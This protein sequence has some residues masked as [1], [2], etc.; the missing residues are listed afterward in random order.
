MELL[1]DN[2]L[3]P[4]LPASAFVVVKRETMDALVGQL[5]SP[6]Y[7]S[8]RVLREALFPKGD[9]ELRQA[10][11]ETVATISLSD[12]K[13][14]YST[15]FRPD[16]TTIV[17]VGEVTPEQARQVVE[18]Y[19]GGWKAS[20]LKPITDYPPVP[21]NKPSAF[22]VP[23]SSRVQDEVTLAE[24][25]GIMR[26]D[27]DYYKLKLGNTVLSGAFYASRLSSDL[28]EK[29]GLVYSVESFLEAKKARSIFGIEF[30]CDPPNVT[31]SR[32]ITLRD[33]EAMQTILVTPEELR[34]AKMLLLHHIP[35]SESSVDS[36]A[37][38]LLDRSV[39]DMPLDE[40]LV[41]AQRYREI[42]A[43]Q[44]RDAFAKWIRPMDFVQVTLGPAPE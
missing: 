43:E 18:K 25:I 12:V 34:Q 4:A 23:D 35:L 37:N 27:P 7:H 9:A 41:A 24:T 20:G 21:V 14:Y 33:I 22:T 15:L 1:A 13:D 44:I 19:F 6:A 38:G 28:R 42:T 31:K 40:P 5:K 3:H 10:T 11:P 36:I 29:A 32:T 2:L 8:S 39:Q 30:A 26:T 16:M 17:V